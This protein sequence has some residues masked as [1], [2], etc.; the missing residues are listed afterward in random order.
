MFELVLDWFF[1]TM[2]SSYVMPSKSIK[3]YLRLI[4]I[5]VGTDFTY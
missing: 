3:W 2:I 1:N 4:Q 5:H